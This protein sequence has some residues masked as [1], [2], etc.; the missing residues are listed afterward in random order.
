MF[1]LLQTAL[2]REVMQSPV[3]P[4][5]LFWTEWPLTL[6]SCSR[7]DHDPW[8]EGYGRRSRLELGSPFET[9]SVGPWSSIKDSFLVGLHV[10]NHYATSYIQMECLCMKWWSYL[11]EL[12]RIK[13]VAYVVGYDIGVSK[14]WWQSSCWTWNDAG[15]DVLHCCVFDWQ[16]LSA[17]LVSKVLSVRLDH[18]DCVD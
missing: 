11:I 7:M 1:S 5:Q 9:R 2:A 3:R 17:H 12:S 10:W 15:S 6:T 8:I 13:R 4:F 18:L 16:D 14:V